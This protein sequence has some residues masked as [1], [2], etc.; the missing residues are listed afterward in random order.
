M[1]YKK[2][3]FSKPQSP[4]KFYLSENFHFWKTLA[5]S[6]TINEASLSFYVYCKNFIFIA[7]PSS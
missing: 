2:S 7:L 4:Q 5:P 3:I 1:D 6:I